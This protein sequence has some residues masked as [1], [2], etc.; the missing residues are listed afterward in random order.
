M[1]RVQR[2]MKMQKKKM[3]SRNT[4]CVAKD[5][6]K[7]TACLRRT[8]AGELSGKKMDEQFLKDDVMIKYIHGLPCMAVV[9]GVLSQILPCLPQTGRK[10]S[11][12]QILLLT[13]MRLRLN[14]PIQH[15]AHLYWIDRSAVSTTFT[16]TTDVMLTHLAE[17]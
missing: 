4:Q 8:E 13:L 3:T 15:I 5:V 16:N 12:F 7:L 2:L 1:N 9:M 14:L 6:Q 10:L 11:P 17:G